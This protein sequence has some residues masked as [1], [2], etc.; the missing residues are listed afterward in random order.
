MIRNRTRARAV[1]WIAAVILASIG[2]WFAPRLFPRARNPQSRHGEGPRDEV[3]VLNLAEIIRRDFRGKALWP[4]P[5]RLVPWLKDKNGRDI[6]IITT[7]DGVQVAA[8]GDDG[9][10]GSEDD[11]TTK[12]DW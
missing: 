4:I 9:I 8:V 12:V 1:P 5:Q 7:L 6:A 11:V 2:L 3:A 10:L